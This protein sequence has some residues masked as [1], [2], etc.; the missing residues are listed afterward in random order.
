LTDIEKISDE[1]LFKPPPPKEDCPICLLLMPSMGTIYM[2][3]CGKVICSGCMHA[4]VYDNRGNIAE[5][6]CPFCRV[7]RHN[8]YEESIEREKK[9]I[10]LDDPI[11]IHNH[12]IYY[13]DG[14]HGFSQDTTKAIEHWHRA[15]ELGHA[16][17]YNS[18]GYA[19]Q[20][21]IGVEV[22]N[23]KAIYYYEQAAMR[24]DESARHNLGSWEERVGNWERA[25]KHYMIAI[26]GGDNDSLKIIQHLYSIGKVIKKDYMRALRLYQIYLS[27][28]KSVQ[29]DKAAVE[30]EHYRYY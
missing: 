24:G 9:R 23:E 17:A 3:C 18:I 13:R 5:E 30:N 4:P 8:S 27:E 7:P 11:A 1:E 15:A 28:I 14:L 21:G 2:A 12:G 19:Y 20:F 25:L 16:N 29:R 26:R 6:K 10:A 22:D